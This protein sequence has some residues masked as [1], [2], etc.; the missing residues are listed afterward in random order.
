[1]SI[2]FARCVVPTWINRNCWFS[3]SLALRE[4]SLAAPVFPFLN[5]HFQIAVQPGILTEVEEEEPFC[6]DSQPL[7][8]YLF[9]YIYS[10]IFIYLFIYSPIF[11]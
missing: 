1:M 11:I 10:S 5:Q 3:E 6:A 4:F 2:S 9:I 7:H 8:Y